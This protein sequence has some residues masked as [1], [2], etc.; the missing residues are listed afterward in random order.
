MWCQGGLFWICDE[1]SWC[2]MSYSM[3]DTSSRGVDGQM[4]QDNST[5][6][7]NPEQM[8]WSPITFSSRLWMVR[9]TNTPFPSFQL[10]SQCFGGSLKIICPKSLEIMFTPS[11][12]VKMLFGKEFAFTLGAFWLLS[13]VIGLDLIGFKILPFKAS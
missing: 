6:Q 1:L 2:C 3:D 9:L 4:G 12:L 8:I 13:N 10:N 5:T 11:S 7:H